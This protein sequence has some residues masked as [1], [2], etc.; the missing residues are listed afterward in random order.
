MGFLKSLFGVTDD[1]AVS[2][3]QQSADKDFEILKNDGIRALHQ[4]QCNAEYAAKCFEHAL[5]IKDDAE[6]REL[7]AR[8]LYQLGEY[9]KSEEQY[10]RL[11]ELEPD[12]AAL[13][14]RKAEV[15]YMADMHDVV[16]ADCAKVLELEPSNSRACLLYAR[17]YIATGNDIQ[18]IAMLTK[19]ITIDDDNLDAYLL[20][21]QLLLK[22]G[23]RNGAEEDA[24]KLVEEAPE[25]EDAQLLMARV[26][27]AQGRHEEAIGIYNKVADLNPFSIEAFKERGAVKLALGDKAGAEADMRQVL[28]IA[29]DALDGTN[30]DF[31]AE[32]HEGIQCQVEQAYRNINPLGI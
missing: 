6:V 2:K 14:M 4:C 8:A 16:A 32:G 26:T 27:E 13:I 30:G 9:A 19:A 20:R 7:L 21:G 29:P 10:A 17:S 24:V 3:Q 28:E 31:T 12:N 1:N 22:L 18:A 5:A 25:S 11:A 15:A 23:D